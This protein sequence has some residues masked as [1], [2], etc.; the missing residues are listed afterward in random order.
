MPLFSDVLFAV[1]VAIA[2]AKL[3]QKNGYVCLLRPRVPDVTFS[4][5]RDLIVLSPYVHASPSPGPY[6]PG[7]RPTGIWLDSGW[8]NFIFQV[9]SDKLSLIHLS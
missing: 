1:V 4:R 3:K 2:V 8:G 7:P 9:N 5:H 6:V